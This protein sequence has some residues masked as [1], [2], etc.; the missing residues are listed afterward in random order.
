MCHQP[1]ESLF[2]IFSRIL[3]FTG[4]T[5]DFDGGDLFGSEF[6]PAESVFV[7]TVS[8]FVV[9]GGVATAARRDINTNDERAGT[10]KEVALDDSDNVELVFKP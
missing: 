8:V 6:E 4:D 3:I 5:I 1:G 10:L 2:L 9:T 7:K